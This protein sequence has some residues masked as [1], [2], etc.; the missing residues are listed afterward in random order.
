M[1]MY[2]DSITVADTITTIVTNAMLIVSNDN[3][4]SAVHSN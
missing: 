3:N 1:Q 4:S 2:V